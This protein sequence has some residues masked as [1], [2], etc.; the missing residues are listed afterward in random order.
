MLTVVCCLGHTR[1]YGEVR[2]WEWVNNRPGRIQRKG[3][4]NKWELGNDVEMQKYK[5]KR[6]RRSSIQSKKR[7]VQE[8]EKRRKRARKI[9]RMKLGEQRKKKKRIERETQKSKVGLQK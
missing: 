8:R 2:K 9:K 5:G 7:D 3:I 1:K 4:G 6:K